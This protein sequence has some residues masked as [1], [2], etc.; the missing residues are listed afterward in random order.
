MFG[1]PEYAHPWSS[2]RAMDLESEE[3]NMR[4]AGQVLS[5][6]IL[7]ASVATPAVA[8]DWPT[9]PVAMLYPLTAG[10]AGDG[11]GRILPLRMSEILGQPEI[12]ENAGRARCMTGLTR[13]AHADADGYVLL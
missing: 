10:S 8:C 4:L 5:I 13:V 1:L 9:R 2:D 7:A 11:I 6:G 12:L 3:P